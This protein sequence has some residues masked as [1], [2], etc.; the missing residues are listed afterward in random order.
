MDFNVVRLTLYGLL[1]SLEADLR[2][3][4][5]EQVCKSCNLI[6]LVQPSLADKLN[7]RA[8]RDGVLG[9]SDLI[10]YLDFSDTLQLLNAH[11]NLLDPNV[12]RTLKAHSSAL[13]R[14][15][16]IR[17]RVMHSRPLQFEDYSYV[18]DTTK[19]LTM[20]S[21]SLFFTLNEFATKLSNDPNYVLNL[22]PPIDDN[23]SHQTHNLPTPDFDETGF[24][25]REAERRALAAAIRGP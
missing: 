1:T 22:R 23:A 5:R 7:A 8:E 2:R 12:S 18:I 4:L 6:E 21:K 3:V 15:A 19:K 16:P 14:L 10:E 9:A 25:G 13:E 11:K 17:N 20:A 24:L